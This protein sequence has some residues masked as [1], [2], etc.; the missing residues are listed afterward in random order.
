MPQMLRDAQGEYTVLYDNPMTRMGR[1]EE[2]AGFLRMNE[3]STNIFAATQDPTVFDYYNYDVA[4]PAMADIQAVPVSWLNDPATIEGKRADRAKQAQ[5]AQM[6][7]MAPAAS[8]MMKTLM[9][10][11]PAAAA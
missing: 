6:A 11:A 10:K 3:Y 7:E 2:L 8:N 4:I 5:Q 9:P 1:S